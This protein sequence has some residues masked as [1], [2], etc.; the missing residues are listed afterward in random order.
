M[1]Q[2]LLVTLGEDM[3]L[4]A[5]LNN[6]IINTIAQG[7]DGKGTIVVFT[8]GNE[9]DTN[10]RYPGNNNSDILVVGAIA[11]NGE[12][13]SYVSCDA[14]YQW[15]SCYGS[16]LDIMA[17]G[18]FIPTTT[19]TG[20]YT[21]SF[22][23][24]SSACP[25]VAGVAALILSVNPTLT[26]QQVRDI[27]ESTAQ[28]IRT[29]LYPYTSTTGRPN[30]TWHEQMGYGLVD[31]YAAV[32]GSCAVPVNFTNQT[33]TTNT[34]ITSCGDIHVQNVSVQSGAKLTLDAAGET[35][36]NGNFEVDLGSELEI[37]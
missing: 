6:A 27:I 25:H 4:Q 19:Y 2:I 31:A 5:S 26:G 16:Q 7:R 34:T 18:V 29:D 21:Q 17:P 9:N 36:I 35:V 20:G 1:A 23:G 32:Q 8:A 24:T 33:V 37:E 11:P 15:G 22:N 12:R 13:K 30:G 10:I 28:K 14:E 3:L